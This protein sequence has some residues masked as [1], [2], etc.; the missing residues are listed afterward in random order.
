[1]IEKGRISNIQTG[2]LA[3]TSLTI[4]GHLILLTVVINQSQQDG[5]IAAILGTILGLI[6]VVAITKLSQHFP[7]VTLIE[8]LFKHF[9]TLGKFIGVLYL[10]YFYIMVILGVRL[11][12]EAYRMMM[13]ETPLWAFT[14]VIVLLTTYLVFIGLETLARTNQIVL[15]IIVFIAIIVVLLTMGNKDYSNLLPVFGQGFPPIGVGAISV[16]AWFG[17]FVI[18]GMI[19][20][21]VQRPQ[22]ILKTNIFAAVI[23]LIF[24]L[25]PITGPIAMFGPQEAARLPFP[26]FSAVRYINAGEI[27]NRFDAIAAI[28]WTVGLMV[29]VSVF[30]YGLI[31]GTA[32]AFNLRSY[33]SLIIP[34]AW[35]IAVGALLFIRDFMELTEFMFE[36]Y[37]PLNIL[38]GIALPV[39]L[40]LFA[41]RLKKKS[42]QTKQS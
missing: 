25:G 6:G 29:R 21:Y 36:T 5:W 15:P 28:F 41:R 10:V 32:Q 9:G 14:L 26:T 42:P 34:F 13:F 8:I 37:I 1:M 20:P 7:G 31:L 33:R 12:G 35:L 40:V 24:F 30:Y 2:M 18:L 17:E 27:I 19:L 38:M 16:M 3:V 11:F 4:I 39:I 22:K 23:V